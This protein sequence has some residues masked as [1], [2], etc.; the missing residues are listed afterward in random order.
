MA[1]TA[2]AEQPVGLVLQGGA[3]AIH[4]PGRETPIDAA[5]GVDLFA[6]DR[7]V[8][9]NAP[10]VF[11]FCPST[12]IQTLAANHEYP[13]EASAPAAAPPFLSTQ[14]VPICELPA[15]SRMGVAPLTPRPTVT[16]EGTFE[17]REAALPE[18]KRSMFRD[19]WATLDRAAAQWELLVAVSRASVLEDAGLA[20]DA[21]AQCDLIAARWPAALWTREVSTRIA[22]DETA[23]RGVRVAPAETHQTTPSGKTYAFLVGI[24]Q[25]RENSGVPWL[26]YADKDAE[27]FAAYLRTPRG[28]S[29]RLC[30]E[31]QTVDCEVRLLENQQASLAR[32]SSEL[33]SFASDKHHVS[34]DNTFIL[35]IAAH[36]ADPAMEKDWEHNTKIRKE[37][38]I[39]TWDSD[40]NETKVSGY[41]MSELRDLMAREALQYGRVLVFADVCRAGNIGPIAGTS[42]LQPAVREV[43]VQKEGSMGLFMASQSGEDA[44][45]SSKF[46]G[47]H[48]AFSYFVLD[49]LN[50][51]PA[52]AQQLI[53]ADL[54][55]HIVQGV[56]RVT[57]DKQIPIGRAVDERM[58][59]PDNLKE[60]PMTLPPAVP[61]DKTT[62]RRP[63]GLRPSAPKNLAPAPPRPQPADEFERA[64]AQEH[65]RRDEPGNAFAVLDRLRADPSTPP[66]ILDSRAEQLRIALEDRGQRVILQYLR[67]EQSPPEPEKFEAA[68]KDFQAALELAPAAAFN[69]ARMLFCRGRAMIFHHNYKDALDALQES[70]RLDPTRAYAYNA[71]GI[72]YLEQAARDTSLLASAQ[73]AFHDAI[74]YAPYWPYP[75]HNLALASI[76]LGDFDS[77]AADYR[78]AME[79]APDYPYLPYNLALL[80]QRLN[81]IP[82]ARQYYRQ[83][84]ATA[85]Q[86]RA[87]GVLFHADGTRPEDAL[88][89][90][91]LGTLAA[92]RHD[93]AAAE[94]EY[95][96]AL[97]DAPS[98][99]SARY[100]LAMLLTSGGRV[101]QEAEDL[102]KLNLA[103]DPHHLTTRL[104]Y[105]RYLAATGRLDEAIGQ[106]R[107]ALD[108]AN[109]LVPLRRDLAAALTAD[110]KP[111]EARTVLEAA[112]LK[113]PEDPALLDQLA[114]TEAALGNQSGAAE[115]R[116]RAA[117]LRRH[118]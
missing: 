2:R 53:F 76:E 83:A 26:N 67:G 52:G 32:V 16:A 14:P 55:D 78:R 81:R 91:A 84:L 89:H 96:Q 100:N 6:R 104:A 43:F 61:V 57:L 7:L 87:S 58:P 107:L 4:R 46:G 71:I 118:R 92:A 19:Q 48:G 82:V 79:I 86:G 5:P 49:G 113:A 64:L 94:K 56:R 112:L 60:P 20:A 12:A 54:R 101:S 1:A 93:S 39:L 17:T 66:D 74:H 22:R 90:N 110:H 69:E 88:T 77:A 18:P 8:A 21:I 65:L 68:E 15:M 42:E 44:F 40:Y 47:G 70:T 63:R 34:R 51:N 45:E 11:A 33:E 25:Y 85:E 97:R 72:A 28:G 111:G 115:Y 117:A 95:R 24:S 13:L 106:F 109:D 75:W 9:G 116:R 23:S 35:F 50:T 105:G 99:L 27:A 80:Y 114:D 62:L 59:V 31:H 10:I 30:P 29:L 108:D 73:A 3:G 36:G 103:E 41:L 102:W 98:N 37:P 38:I